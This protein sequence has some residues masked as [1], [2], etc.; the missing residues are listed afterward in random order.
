M[1]I[2]LSKLLTRVFLFFLFFYFSTATI[3][4]QADFG[5]GLQGGSPS[6]ITVKLHDPR[7]MSLEFLAAW[8]KLRDMYF[9]NVH[10]LWETELGGGPI[11]I[12][13]GPGLFAG[14]ER[15]RDTYRRGHM[16]VAGV[17]ANVG[18]QLF[19]GQVE[20]YGQ[21]T[22]RVTGIGGFSFALG[23]GLGVRFYFS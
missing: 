20:T 16:F 22:P 9:L 21:L 8:D 18:L 12:I 23:G 17:T 6:G 13:Y 5:I 11:H 3:S 15:L 1:Q 7:A 19:F 10:G 14:G 4:A 2:T